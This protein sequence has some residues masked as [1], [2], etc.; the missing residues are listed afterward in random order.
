MVP[1]PQIPVEPT[2]IVGTL[3]NDS[4]APAIK[5]N[6][7]EILILAVL[8]VCMIPIAIQSKSVKVNRFAIIKL[9]RFYKIGLF[10]ALFEC[11]STGCIW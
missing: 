1:A 4:C 6:L 7:M 5:T 2:P 11:S 3:G 10:L 9:A 8:I